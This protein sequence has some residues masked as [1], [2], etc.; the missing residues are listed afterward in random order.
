MRKPSGFLCSRLLFFILGCRLVQWISCWRGL[1]V[2]SRCPRSRRRPRR[3]H[4]WHGA[5]HRHM[6]GGHHHWRHSGVRHH[7]HAHHWVL[8]LRNQH[9]LR[10]RLSGSGSAMSL[11]HS[12]SPSYKQ[13]MLCRTPQVAIC[14]SQYVITRFDLMFDM[15]DGA[16]VWDLTQHAKQCKRPWDLTQHLKQ[17]KRTLDLT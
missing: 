17:C 6:M 11:W 13:L 7:S 10:A 2:R 16:K 5:R 9:L 8:K 4:A 3:H 15:H 1:S 12:R 14:L